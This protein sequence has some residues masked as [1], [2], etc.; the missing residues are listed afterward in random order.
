MKS[1]YDTKA[2]EMNVQA[3]D[4][5][6]FYNPQ[7]KKG[8]SPKLQ[9]PWDGPYTVLDRL[10][11]DVEITLKLKYKWM[12]MVYQGEKWINKRIKTFNE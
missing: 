1:K 11:H 9:S 12:V 4:N 8:Q 7:W 5:V 2:N 6:W 3:G 10:S